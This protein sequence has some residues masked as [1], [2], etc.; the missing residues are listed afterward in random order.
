MLVQVALPV[1]LYRVFDYSLPADMSALP[2]T[3]ATQ[4]PQ[5]GSRVEVSFGRQTLIGI[6]VSS[7][8]S[9]GQQRTT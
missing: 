1:P 3:T 6:V 8:C 5:I 9:S 2:N 4:I 7:Y